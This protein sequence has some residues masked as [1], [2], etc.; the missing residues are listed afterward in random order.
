MHFTAVCIR[1]LSNASTSVLSPWPALV[2]LEGL[3]GILLLPL[4]LFW[5][6]SDALFLQ[7]RSGRKQKRQCVSF[8]LKLRTQHYYFL[9]GAKRKGCL[10]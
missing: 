8:V 6:C 2:A 9:T 3:S 10:K 7:G 5:V 1:W 4:S